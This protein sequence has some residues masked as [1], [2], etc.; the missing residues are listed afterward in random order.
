MIWGCREP[1]MEMGVQRAGDGNG[2]AESRRWA[3]PGV[4]GPV[5]TAPVTSMEGR[6]CSRAE[7]LRRTVPKSLLSP[8]QTAP[9]TLNVTKGGDGYILN[10]EVMTYYNH[11]EYTYEVQYKKD[12]A[13]W[14]VRGLR[15]LLGGSGGM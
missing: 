3:G 13:S 2:G 6:G 12:A 5:K 10:W 14:E 15:G 1:E 9:P 7:M 11:I 8:V 4:L